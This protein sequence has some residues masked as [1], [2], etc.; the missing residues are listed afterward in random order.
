MR[1]L[2]RVLT[3]AACAATLG[4][5]GMAMDS[6]E[7]G[8]PSG[9]GDFGA[10]QGGVQDMSFARELVAQGRVPPADAFV[11]EAMFSEHDLPLEGAPCSTLLCLRGS[12]GV[13][14]SATLDPAAW[15][16]VG[17]SSTID[18]EQFERPPIAIVATVDVSGSMGWSYAGSNSPGEISRTLLQAIAAE[19]GPQDQVALVTYGSHVS[20]A[21]PWVAGDDPAVDAAISAL[22]EGGSTNMEGGLNRAFALAGDAA[23]QE[24]E[25]RVM[26][27]TDV[28]PNVGA[29]TPSEFETMTANAAAEGIGLTV[30]GVGLG[31]GAEIFKAM[32]HLRGGNAFSLMSEEAVAPFM[33]DNWPW[34]VSPIAYDLQVQADP[35]VALGLVAGYGFPQSEGAPSASLD[36][37]TVFLSK[38]KGALLLELEPLDGAALE[39]TR[40]DLS[41]SYT[42]PSGEPF[43]QAIHV[44]YDGQPVD[45][46]GVYLPQIGIAKAVPLALLV[47]AMHDAAEAYGSSPAQSV[48][49]LE[50]A[51]ERF[52]TDAAAVGDEQLQTE[53]EFWTQLLDLMKAG[54]PQ[55]SMYPGG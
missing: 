8:M 37:A 43:Q 13:A 17:L 44:S 29:S 19:L 36:V 47:T 33:E 20:T 9:G 55:G 7:T 53:A 2:L 54:A 28:Q 10:T 25:V 27:F 16:Q 40:V 50:P 3:V 5:C 35:S 23:D 34:M 4:G 18:P 52:A 49:L 11:V 1:R 26:L 42:D 39:G 30:Y 45:A 41:L 46:R 12:M 6:M 32:S 15:V 22:G 24:R 48:T 38:R 31:M 51:L 21:L 14:P